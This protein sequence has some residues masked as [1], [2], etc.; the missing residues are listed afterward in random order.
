M[1]IAAAAFNAGEKKNRGWVECAQVGA[2]VCPLHAAPAC[3]GWTGDARIH[4]HASAVVRLS[5]HVP[6][7]AHVRARAVAGA[8]VAADAR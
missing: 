1:A 7:F 2:R 5:M 6:W 8:W 3:A 4:M